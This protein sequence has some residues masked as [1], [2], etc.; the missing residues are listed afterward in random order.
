VPHADDELTV[1]S[2]ASKKL[3]KELPPDDEMQLTL[4]GLLHANDQA[5]ALTGASHLEYA[6][7][8]ILKAFFRP[9]NSTDTKRMFDGSANAVLGTASSKIR[10]VFAVNL[11]SEEQYHDMMLINDIRNVFAHTLHNID[12]TNHLIVKDCN[13]LLSYKSSIGGVLPPPNNSKE[14]YLYTIAHLYFNIRA[15]VHRY[16]VAKILSNPSLDQVKPLPDK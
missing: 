14:Q 1:A 9:L 12:F 16:E 13:K 3:L 5:A 11:I 7:E 2:A 10:L 15:K 6:L 8:I 4:I